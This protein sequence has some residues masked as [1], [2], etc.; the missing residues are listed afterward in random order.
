MVE[1][2]GRVDSW[3][4]A[5]SFSMAPD[6]LCL[7]STEWTGTESVTLSFPWLVVVLFPGM[8]ISMHGLGFQGLKKHV[9]SPK[10]LELVTSSIPGGRAAVLD[11]HREMMLVYTE[12]PS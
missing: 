7:P 1:A 9:S 6:H 5:I 4:D 3:V 11:L 12:R 2:W 10:T 8:C